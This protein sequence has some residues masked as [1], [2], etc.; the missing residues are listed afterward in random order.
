MI[1][2]ELPDGSIAEFPDGTSDNIIRTTLLRE[3]KPESKVSQDTRGELSRLTQKVG[4]DKGSFL[5]TADS[6][7]RGAADTMSFGLADEMSAGLGALTGLGGEFGDYSGNLRRQRIA[8]EIRDQND[9]VAST[10]GRVSGAVGS[11]LG[12]LKN[13]LSFAGRAARSGGGLGR[14]AR[15]SLADSALAGGAYSAGSGE[16]AEDRATQGGIGAIA[17][18]G[19]G[20]LTP[21]G[22]AGAQALGKQALAPIL[23]RLQPGKYSLDALYQTL[24]RAGMSPN[25]VAEVLSRSQADE[26]GMFTVADA[27][28]NPGQRLLSSVVRSPNDARR[29]VVDTLTERQMGQGDRLGRYLAEGF[30]APDTAAQRTASL[31]ADRNAMAGVNYDAARQG[32]GAVDVS[33]AIAA[34]DD[35]LTPG[36]TRLANPGTNIAD[37][38]LEGVVRR[39]RSLLTDG[40]SAITDFNGVLRAKQDISDMIGAAQRS[41]RNNQVRLLSQIN[42]QLDSALERASPQYRAAN[43]AYRAQSQTID[44]VEA[45]RQATSSRTRAADNIQRFNA[46]EPGERSAFRAGYA[47]PMIAR[48]EAGSISPT[49]NKARSL[50]TEKTGQ[51]FPAIAEPRRADKMGRR[52]AR[53]QRMFETANAALGGSKTADNLA[54]MAELSKFD[55]SI[56]SNLV[57]GRPIQA[58]MSAVNTAL[59]EARGLPPTVTTRLARALMGTDP[60]AA[61]QLLAAGVGQRQIT[62]QQRAAY[63]A[64]LNRLGTAL[65]IPA[66]Q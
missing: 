49:T 26:Q 48:V 41:G 4:E 44:A 38:S 57:Q 50:M 23:S 59:N 36:V 19:L 45:G 21:Y 66:L 47:D 56:I 35:I 52:I 24:R 22:V 28:G 43:D 27:L 15:G 31:T 58:A 62:Q 39:A 51:E 30:N 1:E 54:D 20:F 10:A 65:G 60:E 32:A 3:F 7:M 34:A 53:E 16:D 8:Q 17:G 55:P 14:I 33:G 63:S 2:I 25:D 18:A 46:M 40:R 64:V 6:F 37:D 61:R 9:P 13:G 29:E 11:G 12:L 5:R 42:Q